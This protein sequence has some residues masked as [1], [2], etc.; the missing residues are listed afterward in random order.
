[1]TEW[2]IDCLS[3][4]P[5]QWTNGEY[6]NLLLDLTLT[7][8]FKSFI[9]LKRTH[10]NGG[11][12]TLDYNKIQKIPRLVLLNI[13]EV[14][15]TFSFSVTR[16]W[17][18]FLFVNY[19][20]LVHIC[21]SAIDFSH[22]HPMKPKRISTVLETLSVNIS[23]LP[24]EIQSRSHTGGL[25]CIKT[26]IYWEKEPQNKIIKILCSFRNYLV[27][28]GLIITYKSK[29]VEIAQRVKRKWSG[30]VVSNSLWLHGL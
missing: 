11:Q 8:I 17:V 2:F 25:E 19:M 3:N 30:L 1:M 13:S 28:K 12:Y 22:L 27:M 5:F 20:L 10:G 16:G 7:Q 29:R 26:S 6:K 9:W 15:I 18:C 21:L 24:A 14:Q 4:V 23:T